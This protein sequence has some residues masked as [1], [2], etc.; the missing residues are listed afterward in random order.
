MIR[1]HRNVMSGVNVLLL[2]G[3]FLMLMV[4]SH[5]NVCVCPENEYHN[6]SGLV[7]LLP[8]NLLPLYTY[9]YYGAME[10]NLT[11]VYD[12]YELSLIRDWI[13]FF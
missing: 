3:C 1:S 6:H 9:I 7:K 5:R 12:F 2:L 10:N 8:V 11:A 4:R 13:V